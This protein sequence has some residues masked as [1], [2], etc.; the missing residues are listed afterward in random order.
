MPFLLASVIL[1]WAHLIAVMRSLQNGGPPHVLHIPALVG[2]MLAS[3]D[4]FY[5]SPLNSRGIPGDAR[6]WVPAGVLIVG[7]ASI[8]V[9]G[10]KFYTIY[11][12]G[13]DQSRAGWRSGIS[14]ACVVLGIYMTGAA[15]DHFV[16]FSDSNKTG[17]AAPDLLGVKDVQ[18]PQMVL[19]RI[20]ETGAD[21]RCPVSI[22]F[23]GMS[24]TPFVPWPSYV[25]GHSVEM[26]AAIE[27]ASREADRHDSK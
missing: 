12:D 18:C 11:R 22:S 26:K 15:I 27:S 14:L 16:F 8:A 25:T 1:G 17:T 9:F 23:G 21:F 24:S 13:G 10:W 20:T 4:T 2:F 19:I 6:N 5:L 3:L 7:L